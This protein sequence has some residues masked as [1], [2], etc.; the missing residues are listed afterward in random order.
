[1]MEK[2]TIARPYAQAVFDHARE[3]D[4]FEH[5][6][7]L[8][9]L[10]SDIVTDSLMRTLINNPRVS[11]DVLFEILREICG[12]LLDKK[13]GNLV[14]ILIDAGRLSVLPEIYDLY[15]NMWADH[16]GIAEVTVVSAY[17]LSDAQS[18]SI[19]EAMARKLGKKIDIK[20]RVDESLI[21]GAV[22]SAGDSAIDASIRGRL[23]QLAN[24]FI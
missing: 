2:I 3:E 15:H 12:N 6:S 1:M 14:R 7:S 5:W 24:E 20:S 9:K 4:R 21:G 17:P 10:L 19:N 18:Q 13:G 16:E 23:Q 11:D 8:L 22:I